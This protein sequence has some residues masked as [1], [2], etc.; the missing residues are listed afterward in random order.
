MLRMHWRLKGLVQKALG[1]VPFGA[2]LHYQLQKRAGG[3]RTFDSEL[4]RKIDDWCLMTGHLRSVG[5]PVA[6]TRFLEIGTG[7]YP[8]FPCCLYLAGAKSVITVDLHRHLKPQ[9][10]QRMADALTRFLPAIASAT[11]RSEQRLAELQ[12]EFASAVRRG[13]SLEE[14]SGGVIEYRAPA[15]ASMTKL[16][17][18]AVDVVF[19]NS[20]LE[21][22]PPPV[23]ADC[24]AEAHRILR[25]GGVVFHSVN[26]GDHYAYVDRNVHQLNYLQFSDAEWK[27][28]NNRFLY[29]NRLRA[30]DFL[31]MARTTGF[32]IEVD[33]SRPHPMRLQQLDTIR[34]RPQFARY[35][36]EQ[37]A[38]TS[39][40]FIG[41]R[42]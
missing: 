29:Q 1:Y 37:L 26:C 9:L 7:W 40:D 28:W 32:S 42:Q 4:A 18:A 15:D 30:A 41:R 17:A 19:S 35:S 27:L 36:R 25:P 10:T 39:I 22:V 24:F 33:T 20:V 6:G 16:P 12:R 5:V 2:W 38:I 3:L 23:I 34:V 8:T 31:D 14:A 21:H 11:G 13:A